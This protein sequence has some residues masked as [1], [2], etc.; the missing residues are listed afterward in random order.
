MS[1]RPIMVS[2]AVSCWLLLVV[3]ATAFGQSST[4]TSNASST[5]VSYAS[6]NQLNQL[7][8][9][10]EQASQQTQVDLARLRVDKWKAD[11]NT[12]RQTQAD[13]DSIERNLQSA[14]PAMIT[15]SRSAP[16]QLAPTFKIYRN[17][18]ALSDVFT[19]VAENAGAFGSKDDYEI[20]GGDLTSFEKSRRAFADR[21]EEL[22]G[23]KDNELLQL[24]TQVHQLEASAQ[25][26]ASPKKVVVDDTEP[27][28]KAP[29]KK[30]ATASG[31]KKNGPS[32]AQGSGQ[33]P[34]SS[35]NSQSQQPQ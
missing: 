22:A 34:A 21:I 4:S 7:L 2:C 10:L 30:K 9:S 24:R 18:D 20:V 19:S 23:T 17:L 33:K 25:P 32:T 1:L 16:D 12:K 35:A 8:A 28:K 13:I 27:P 29:A 3:G 15:Q 5:P 11:S 6:V 26:A 14:L 31:A